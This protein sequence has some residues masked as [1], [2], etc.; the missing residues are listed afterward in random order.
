MGLLGSGKNALNRLLEPLNIRVDSLTAERAEARR[1]AELVRTGHFGRAAFPELPQFRDCDPMPV[2]AA[3]RTFEPEMEKF[4]ARDVPGQYSYANGY[5][6]SPDAEILYAMV[7]LH[8]PGRIVEIGS[9]SSTLLFRA[10][11][12]DASLDTRLTSIDPDPRRAVSLHADEVIR[13]RFESP[14]VDTPI[15]N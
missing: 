7:R 4:T 10:A 13:E 6:D 3:V 2:L 14:A 12:N 15:A 9:G 11:I 5:F 8:K 1:L